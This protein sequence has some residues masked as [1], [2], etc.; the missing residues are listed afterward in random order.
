MDFKTDTIGKSYC[1][2]NKFLIGKS[3]SDFYNAE[4]FIS[5]FNESSK[6]ENSL[7]SII[8]NSLHLT[9]KVE[10]ILLSQ[11]N[12]NIKQVF[13]CDWFFK[14]S[15]KPDEF[16][17]KIFPNVS[18]SL[19]CKLFTK[20]S[21][22]IAN[23]K[24]AEV[25]M[26]FIQKNY[27]KSSGEIF[28]PKC[29]VNFIKN[30]FSNEKPFLQHVKADKIW[31]NISRRHPSLFLEIL[32]NYFDSSN[33]EYKNYFQH[34]K[35]LLF[36]AAN[37]SD[38][39]IPFYIKYYS[40]L[41]Y[42]NFGIKLTRKL[43][44]KLKEVI[45]K[46]NHLIQSSS[47]FKR[48][49]LFKAFSFNDQV[50]F[51]VSLV[52]FKK[53]KLTFFNWI[54]S[55]YEITLLMLSV[56]PNKRLQMLE[57]VF[58]EL[59]ELIPLDQ[60]LNYVVAYEKELTDP[61]NEKYE[62]CKFNEGLNTWEP[63]DEMENFVYLFPFDSAFSR[64][65][66][67][68]SKACVLYKRQD[69]VQFMIKLCAI[70]RD[71]INL[72][73][74]VDYVFTRFRNDSTQVFIQ[75]MTDVFRN[76]SLTLLDVTVIEK[77]EEMLELCFLR[78]DRYSYSY[79][80]EKCM[81]YRLHKNM[82][83]DFL[84]K[85]MIDWKISEGIEEDFIHDFKNV[86]A[87]KLFFRFY[88]ELIKWMTSNP[89]NKK[90]SKTIPNWILMTISD[91]NTNNLKT[92]IIVTDVP[93][94]IRHINLIVKKN[95]N[96]VL[97]DVDTVETLKNKSVSLFLTQSKAN[98]F[99]YLLKH[100]P[101][102]ICD[103]FDNF[104]SFL[105]S[106]F[107]EPGIKDVFFS[108]LKMLS[109]MSL[110]EKLFTNISKEFQENKNVAIKRN[111]YFKEVLWSFQNCC[112]HSRTDEIVPKLMNILKD[113]N[114][115]KIAIKKELIRVLVNITNFSESLVISNKCWSMIDHYST[116]TVLLKK[117]TSSFLEQP[118]EETFN[119]LKKF[120]SESDELVIESRPP[121]KDIP[122]KYFEDYVLTLWT[123]S[124]KQSPRLKNHLQDSILS[125]FRTVTHE[126]S[127][128][129]M[130]ILNA[131]LENWP[132]T[133]NTVLFED[134]LIIT[135]YEMYFRLFNK[136]QNT[137]VEHKSEQF[138]KELRK[139]FCGYTEYNHLSLLFLKS[140]DAFIKELNS[141]KQNFDILSTL[142]ELLNEPQDITLAIFVILT[143]SDDFVKLYKSD[144]RNLNAQEKAHMNTLS[145]IVNSLSSNQ[146]YV[147]Q[148][149]F[150]KKFGIDD[151]ELQSHMD[152]TSTG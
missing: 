112:Y 73:T 14:E 130:I 52:I 135:Y 152:T 51:L 56:T 77:I 97:N 79:L 62:N 137:S 15:L 59:L 145:D 43:G 61:N 21:K 121:L 26:Q 13:K 94:L 8:I 144:N 83:V 93:E 151:A 19:R 68:L 18:A 114:I 140:F 32:S 110:N 10:E 45:F 63:P 1:K 150:K 27:S 66:Q 67:M 72:K 115:S 58:K 76:F 44:G 116:R 85:K 92:P 111:N 84:I 37:H 129:A 3:V 54:N 7:Q 50:K 46:S 20:L 146:N 117:V 136:F 141:H 124:E 127:K 108:C 74:V 60:R 31:L 139:L 120:I 69:L 128:S 24:D 38:L 2:L 47:I 105:I 28:L 100:H 91:Y 25:L 75:F 119:T 70:N 131:I 53:N 40:K 39:F 142:K 133:T 102:I 81:Y 113:S 149:H 89:D 126:D 143:I 87:R 82:E 4:E 107:E 96:D 49:V 125:V 90:S 36:L 57:S 33:P 123:F 101:Q 35:A 134:Y 16:C 29:D 99:K 106:N 118:S 9:S 95:T 11:N 55:I 132:Y 12:D 30:Y 42:L 103:K 6:F 104:V 23:G 88:K 64:Y 86:D 22:V 78:N 5:S 147:I 41:L 122:L 148:I 80:L 138:G 34:N 98:L 17:T 48:E 65:K 71:Y 109:F